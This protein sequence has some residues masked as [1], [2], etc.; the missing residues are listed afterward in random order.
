MDEM[1]GSEE[2]APNRPIGLVRSEYSESL[3]KQKKVPNEKSVSQPAE[4]LLDMVIP[5]TLLTTEKVNKMVEERFAEME[6]KM[7]GFPVFNSNVALLL[8]VEI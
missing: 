6:M 2:D 4:L 7:I 5:Q 3:E 1:R 8:S